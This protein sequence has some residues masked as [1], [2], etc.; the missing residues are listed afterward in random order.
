MKWLRCT[1]YVSLSGFKTTLKAIINRRREREIVSS[2]K[3]RN[4][5]RGMK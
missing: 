4:K 3:E 5:I 2:I 1:K